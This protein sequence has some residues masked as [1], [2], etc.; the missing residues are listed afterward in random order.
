[1]QISRSITSHGTLEPEAVCWLK[2][3]PDTHLHHVAH[4][5]RHPESTYRFSLARISEKFTRVAEGYLALTAEMSTPTV[6]ESAWRALLDDQDFLLRALQDHLDDCFL[7]LKALIDPATAKPGS[8]LFAD[9]YVTKNLPGAKAFR[10]AMSGYKTNLLIANKLKH[11]QGRLRGVSVR[12][13]SS[14]HLGYYLEAPD[15]NGAMGPSSDIHPDRGSFSFARDLGLRL[16]DVYNCSRQ[17]AKTVQVAMS[18][19][20]GIKLNALQPAQNAGWKKLI[21]TVG[22][23]PM[24]LF[25]KELSKDLARIT[26]ERD[27]TALAIRFPYRTRIILPPPVFVTISAEVDG[28]SPTISVPFP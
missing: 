4:G 27:G 24:A 21:E 2:S 6:E 11:Q 1:M 22:Q 17:L 25:P 15:A 18:A 19:L 14:V 13:P 16:F 10:N 26:V 7:V 28:N 8:S 5:V 9:E 23:L 20:H 3:I 12:M